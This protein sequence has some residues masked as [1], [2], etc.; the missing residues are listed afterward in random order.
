MNVDGQLVGA[1][2]VIAAMLQCTPGDPLLCG[3]LA[4]LHISTEEWLQFTRAI[5]AA[6]V[7]EGVETQ[8]RRLDSTICPVRISAHAIR[9]G[10]GHIE[11]HE[12]LVE[13][14]T[15]QRQ[16]DVERR[17][18]ERLAGLGAA[19]AGV[20]HELNN[21]LTSIIGFVQLLLSKPGAKDVAALETVQREASRSA[22]IVRDLLALASRR[23]TDRRVPVRLNEVV[24]Y[25]LRTRQYAQL[26]H[27]V[28]CTLE[29]DPDLPRVAGDRGQLEQLVLNL[30]SNAEHALH[31]ASGSMPGSGCLSIRTR[32]E[33]DWVVLEVEDNGAGIP[34][35]VRMRIWEPFW[36]TRSGSGTGLGLTVVQSIVA[37]H[38]GQIELAPR[39]TANQR[40]CFVVRLPALTREPREASHGDTRPVMD[41]LVADA[42]VEERSFLTR[43]LSARGHAVLTAASTREAVRLAGRMHFDAVICSAQIAGDG[44]TLAALR[45]VPVEATGRRGVP[46]RIIVAAGDADS[47]ARLPLPLPPGTAIVLHPFD[48]N[49]LLVLLEES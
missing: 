23:E 24:T 7:V 14:R 39:T 32:G 33:A 31:A 10:A 5:A 6:E 47:T 29:L 46:P 37:D 8:W 4:A 17:R 41:V 42:C 3:S 18:S 15:L 44:Q 21:P 12:L 38:G 35:D 30:V 26:L 9:D 27:G 40:T 43:L 2:S 11:G 1:D 20:A 19:L 16:R 45:E 36:T 25:V 13:D 49:E 28:N 22:K 34:E 48:V